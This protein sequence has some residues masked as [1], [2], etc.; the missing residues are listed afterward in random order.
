[1]EMNMANILLNSIKNLK[2]ISRKKFSLGSRGL[3]PFPNA[4]GVTALSRDCLNIFI[5]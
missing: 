1:M 3:P 4:P 2:H 5:A